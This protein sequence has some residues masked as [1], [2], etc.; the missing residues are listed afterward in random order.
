MTNPN[1]HLRR[2][3][4]VTG[5]TSGQLTLL[6]CFS[7]LAIVSAAVASLT[8]LATAQSQIGA[9][10]PPRPTEPRAAKA[11]VAIETHC[12]SCHQAGRLAQPGAA[13][14]LDDI[15]DLKRIG[16]DRS[17]VR[18]GVP[19]VSPLYEAMLLP[20]PRQVLGTQRPPRASPD[21]VLA[22]ADWIADLPPDSVREDTSSAPPPARV[23][24]VTAAAELAMP[25]PELA[26]KLTAMDGAWTPVARRLLLSLVDRADANGLYEAIAG[27]GPAQ[28]PAVSAAPVLD[29]WIEPWPVTPGEVL[30]LRAS[31]TLACHL[32]VINVDAEGKAIVIFP[33]DFERDNLLP[34]G[35]R[36][37]IPEAAAPY[38]LRARGDGPERLIGLCSSAATPP[39]GIT[40]D[41]E[42]LRFTVLGNWRNFTRD[43]AAGV[44]MEGTLRRAIVVGDVPPSP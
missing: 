24:L 33:N 38:V 14:G 23:D 27:V 2:A 31:T 19:D 34:T 25:E 11:Y 37:S 7:F 42:R 21:A 5:A 35:R 16:T 39:Y 29:L 44:P 15:L 6:Y 22:I 12:A 1:R 36:L 26:A 43:A 13:G 28:P 17:L 4:S 40:H 8:G 32:T 30:T 20:H 3:G 18:A 9:S 10:V 41:F